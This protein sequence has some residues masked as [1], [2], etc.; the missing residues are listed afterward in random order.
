MLAVG[1][2][3]LGQTQA[4]AQSEID[5]YGGFWIPFLPD[6][7]AAAIVSNGGGT[8]LRPN[9]VNDDQSDLGGQIGLRGFYNFA[10][11]RTIVEFDV[12]VAGI[13][14]MGS[15]ET[16]ADPGPHVDDLDGQP[17]WQCIPGKQ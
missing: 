7:N 6:Y 16:F 3:S 9:L 11:T 15:R 1:M 5:V 8:V 12:N 17:R 13:D 14:G 2:I 4:S 10:P